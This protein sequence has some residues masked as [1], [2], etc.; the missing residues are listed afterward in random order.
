M[1]NTGETREQRIERLAAELSAETGNIVKVV[2]SVARD[3]QLGAEQ[4][5]A[6]NTAKLKFQRA[7]LLERAYTL[8]EKMDAA[9]GAESPDIGEVMG[10]LLLKTLLAADVNST[11]EDYDGVLKV[12]TQGAKDLTSRKRSPGVPSAFGSKGR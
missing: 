11:M 5:I 6:I 3:A 9:L 10:L 1:S 4:L 7:K 12:L 2:D 8:G